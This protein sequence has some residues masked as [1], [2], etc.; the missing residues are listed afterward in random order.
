M[1]FVL[2]GNIFT[3][4]SNYF[5]LCRKISYWKT[6][7]EEKRM[8]LN[9]K[10]LSYLHSTFSPFY[11]QNKMIFKAN[12]IIRLSI[13]QITLFFFNLRACPPFHRTRGKIYNCKK[14]PTKS[15]NYLPY[16]RSGW[17]RI[18]YRKMVINAVNGGGGGEYLLAKKLGRHFFHPIFSFINF[19]EFLMHNGDRVRKR[20]NGNKS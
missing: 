14:M 2:M 18:Y 9:L 20:G 17:K 7:S 8:S 10:K 12:V 15:D 4:I 5:H 3:P 19:S 6:P 11:M 13:L 16:E 1:F